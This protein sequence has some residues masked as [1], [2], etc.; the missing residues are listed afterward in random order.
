MPQ[1]IL[2]LT[3]QREAKA[4]ARYVTARAS[5]LD[6]AVATTRADLTAAAADMRGTRLIAFLSSVIVP[7]E[8]LARAPMPAYNIHPGSPDFPGLCPEAF[9]LAAGA[10]RFGATAHEMTREVDAGAIVAVEDFAVPPGCGRLHL[11][12]LA[13][14]AAVTL[15]ARIADFCMASDGAL[16][17]LPVAWR[18]RAMRR[19]DYQALLARRPDLMVPADRGLRLQAVGL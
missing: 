10:R 18:G 5:A 4:L 12:D 11:A 3:G 16:A 6:V 7:A 8:I 17:A 13:Y 9:A 14:R 2:I 1:R 15:F 19:G